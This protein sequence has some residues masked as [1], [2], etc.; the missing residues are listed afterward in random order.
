MPTS[1][2][3]CG[4]TLTGSGL[5]LRCG[6]SSGVLSKKTP[7]S[8]P[9]STPAPAPSRPAS[10]PP[11]AAAPSPRPHSSGGAAPREFTPSPYAPPPSTAPAV[12][13]GALGR[14]WFVGRIT[15]VGAERI[16]SVGLEGANAIRS[17]STGMLTAGPRAIAVILGVL[18]APL[19]LLLIPAL[20]GRGRRDSGPD[21]I[22]VPVTPFVV[23]AADGAEFD[24]TIR[25][26]IRG[27]FLKLGEDVEVSGRIDRSRVVRVSSILSLRT[28]AITRGYVDPRART[29]PFAT[30]MS[31]IMI[32][33]LVLVIVSVLSALASFGRS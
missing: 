18:F 32:V 12:T 15:E 33:V 31:I 24:C 27:G 6:Y 1:C 14:L 23:Q 20:T 30:V 19:R 16:E 17:I 8:P 4:G 26:E 5:C 21:R 29:A 22:Q 2:P 13:A 10:P 9:A 3:K 28:R 11:T 25:G 7:V